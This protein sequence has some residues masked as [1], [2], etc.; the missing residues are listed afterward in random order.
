M[1]LKL[2]QKQQIGKERKREASVERRT[3]ETRRRE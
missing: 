3:Q 2:Q 1:K